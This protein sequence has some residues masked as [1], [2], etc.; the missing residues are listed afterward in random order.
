MI[1]LYKDSF[2]TKAGD[3][4]TVD[5][6]DIM[7]AIFNGDFKPSIDY[8]RSLDEKTYKTEKRKLPAVTWSGEFSERVDAGIQSY[9]GLVVLDVDNIDQATITRLKKLFHEDKCVHYA[10]TSP[11]GNG[12]KILYKVNTTA[13]QHLQA[14]LHLQHYFENKYCVKVDDSGKNIS[15]LCYVSYDPQAY[16]NVNSSVFEVDLKVAEIT[17]AYTPNPNFVN[18]K[19]STDLKF[20]FTTCIK[21]VNRTKAYVSGQRNVYVHAM[22]CALNRCGV[23][24]EE[25]EGMLNAEFNDLEPGEVKKCVKSAYFHH[26]GE[27]GSVTVN[28]LSTKE[29][30]APPYVANYTDNVVTNDI[31]RITA[32]LFHHKLEK[33]DIADV[34][35]KVAKYYKSMGY[36]DINRKS[37]GELMN[38]AIAALNNNIA[39]NSAKN[40]LSYETAEDMAAELINMKMDDSGV[41]TNLRPID[42]ALRGSFTPGD[43]FGIIGVGGTFK[44]FLLMYIAYVN[45]LRGIPSLYLSGEMS[46]IQFYERLAMMAISANWHQL[47]TEGTLHAGNINQFIADMNTVIKNNIFVVNGVGFNRV[48][49]RATV[50]NIES[51]TGKR[52]QMIGIDGITQM[53]PQGREEI[54]AAINNTLECKEIAKE[55]NVV[56]LGLMHV[57]GDNNKTLR[58][59]GLKARGGSK[60]IANMDGYFSTSLLIDPSTNDM[61]NDDD[62][63]YIPGKFFLK[64]TDKRG[65]SGVTDAIVNVKPNLHLEYESCDPQRYEMKIQRRN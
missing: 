52:I 33:K 36:I 62:V 46:K 2:S 15:R 63:K 55:L 37:L 19:A 16:L 14:F 20:I 5:E 51:K 30:V 21:W 1:S 6:N 59:T 13:E 28:D 24:M 29:F 10:F 39:H 57:S 40:S 49:I 61:I 9:S 47:I 34:V 60:T 7:H 32:M 53:D 64:F 31:M 8:L 45:A 54:P 26:Q 42:N 44:S 58:D 23:N 65:S 38:Q 35:V 25:A 11:G 27:H 56:V 18:Y 4:M 48:N 43:F 22:A 17:K 50:D 41:I 3:G 12:L